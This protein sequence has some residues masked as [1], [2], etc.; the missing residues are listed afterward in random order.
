MTKIPRS[1]LRGHSFF[2]P[3]CDPF[4]IFSFSHPRQSPA[5]VGAGLPA[6]SLAGVFYCL[7]S[8]DG[9]LPAVCLAGLSVPTFSFFLSLPIRSFRVIRVLL[10][11]I[12]IR[13]YISSLCLCVIHFCFFHSLI[14]TAPLFPCAINAHQ[15]LDLHFFFVPLCDPFL[16][17]P[18]SHPCRSVFVA[19]VFHYFWTA[20]KAVLHSFFVLF[21]SY[22]EGIPSGVVCFSIKKNPRMC[23]DLFFSIVMD[24][25]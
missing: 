20:C 9:H 14:R 18:F 2:V 22:A 1:L 11:R 13:T 25:R 15:H 19:G 21:V 10:I 16:F 12:D 6:I 4:L 24:V 23:G 17:F 5:F 3:L 8:W 7:C